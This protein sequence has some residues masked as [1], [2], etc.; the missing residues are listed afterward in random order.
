MRAI[1][2]EAAGGVVVEGERV[3]V[4]RRPSRDEVRLPKGHVEKGES[5]QETALREVTE[6]S[7]YDDLEI[8]ADLGRQTVEFDY[9]GAHVVRD[10]RYFLIRPQ[11]LHRAK[12]KKKEF[13]WEYLQQY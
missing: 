8:A 6:E 3:L 2:Y 13:R 9:E 10:E 5:A 1:R 4:L 11:G 12:R 7:G